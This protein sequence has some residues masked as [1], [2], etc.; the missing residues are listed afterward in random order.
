M[1][2]CL[3]YSDINTLDQRN[4]VAAGTGIAVCPFTLCLFAQ[5]YQRCT[6]PAIASAL[7]S[8]KYFRLLQG[9]VLRP[10]PAFVVIPC[11]S[12]ELFTRMLMRNPR[13][14]RRKFR[15]ASRLEGYGALIDLAPST[16]IVT[17]NI[18]IRRFPE[19]FDHVVNDPTLLFRF[20]YLCAS[21]A[22]NAVFQ[23]FFF[24][25][26]AVSPMTHQELVPN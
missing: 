6:D 25:S 20:M 11:R 2:L 21:C 13:L 8:I 23:K 3:A 17:M 19:L 22:K 15:S 1:R 7:D 16:E 4:H 12:T 18:F 24:L 9:S 14:S 5:G 10:Y 26:S